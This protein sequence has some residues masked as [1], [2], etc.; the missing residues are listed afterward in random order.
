MAPGMENISDAGQMQQPIMMDPNQLGG[1]QAVTNAFNPYAGSAIDLPNFGT[2][3]NGGNPQGPSYEAEGEEYVLGGQPNVYGDGTVDKI[4]PGLNKIKGP[5]HDGGGVNM[6]GGD[7]IVSAKD[8]F[9]VD[10]SFFDDIN[11]L[12]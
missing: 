1:R 10:D 6:S 12:L 8:D 7:F 2:F 3:A 11:Y 4:A 5:S 9:K